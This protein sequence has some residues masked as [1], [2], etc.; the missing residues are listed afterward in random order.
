MPQ[1]KTLNVSANHLTFVPPETLGRDY[2]FTYCFPTYFLLSTYFRILKVHFGA[3]FLEKVNFSLVLSLLANLSDVRNLDLS[4]NELSTPPS[5]A[6][7]SMHHLRTLS[8]A[9]NPITQVMNDSFLGLDKLE[10]LDISDIRATEYQVMNYAGLSR[11]SM[12]LDALKLFR[13]FQHWNRE[14]VKMSHDFFPLLVRDR[15]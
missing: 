5:H 4:H 15:G 11:S 14:R 12:M 9:G 3:K 1:L 8:L 7:H 6:W 10:F 2:H 13:Q